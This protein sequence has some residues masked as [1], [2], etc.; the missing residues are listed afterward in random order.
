MSD[1][2]L[3]D[4][5]RALE[6][7]FFAKHNEALQRRLQEAG[8][9][10]A[11]QQALAMATGISDPAALDRLAALDVGVEAL[12]ALSLVPLV[13][14][15]WADGTMGQRERAAVLSAAAAGL[16]DKG[17]SY[18]LLEQWLAQPPPPA[19][20]TAWEAYIGAILGTL[21]DTGRRALKSELLDRARAIAESAGGFLGMGRKVSPAEEA[22]LKRLERAL[23]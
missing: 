6:E 16:D 4:R 10:E 9:R 21:D 23:P 22:V 11:K 17:P 18:E 15:A 3:D 2:I 7:A 14:V 20:L 8:E 19:L 1:K 12:A 13:A 5:R